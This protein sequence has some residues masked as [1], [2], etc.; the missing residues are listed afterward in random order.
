MITTYDE[1]GHSINLKEISSFIWILIFLFVPLQK[2]KLPMPKKKYGLK[3]VLHPQPTKG[4]DGKPLLYARPASNFK[5][6]MRRVDDWCHEN[7]GQYQ[8]EITRYFESFLD[9]AAIL[10]A[11]GSRVETPIGSFAPKLKITGK[12]T[13]PDKVGHDD[14]RLGG[15]EFIPSKRFIAALEKHIIYGFLKKE[16]VVERHLVTDPAEL[17]AILENCL[18]PG[19]T[20]AKIFAYY[21]GMKYSTAWNYLNALC[22]GDNPR[23]RRWKEG[24]TVLFKPIRKKNKE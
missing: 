15:I 3:F 24:S 23:I 10:M 2:R 19:Y 7:R 11:D 13:D 17:D 22:K 21:S 5:Y 9:V 12:F 1:E 8:G 20:T 4:E 6:T 16:E 14:V 18:R